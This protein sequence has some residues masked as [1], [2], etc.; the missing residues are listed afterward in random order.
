MTQSAR[1]PGSETVEYGADFGDS[2]LPMFTA[3]T[4]YRY[5]VASSTVLSVY[6]VAA[7]LVSSVPSRKML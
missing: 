2:M 7:T 3:E 1:P 4:S 6:E 5:E